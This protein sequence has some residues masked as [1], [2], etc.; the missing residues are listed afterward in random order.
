MLGNGI[1]ACLL[2]AFVVAAGSIPSRASVV[3]QLTFLSGSS[4][5][6][7]GTVTLDFDAISDTFNLNQGLKP[8]LTSI[9]TSNI[10]GQGAYTLL[11]GDLAD[12]SYFGTGAAGQVYTFTAVQLGVGTSDSLFLHL[13]SHEWQLHKG[14]WY[15]QTVMSGE[16]LI[17]GPG[18]PEEVEAP[19]LETPLPA[20]AIL[21]ASGLGAVTL[22]ARRRKSTNTAFART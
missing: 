20:A 3:Y 15:G 9:T 1:K 16:L 7:S 18:L 10:N 8:I 22:L 21:F 17:S 11:P 14:A 5:V 19:P 6:G 13:Y 4:T 2:A 12:W